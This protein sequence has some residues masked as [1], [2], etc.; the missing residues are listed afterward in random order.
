MLFGNQEKTIML[1]PQTTRNGQPYQRRDAKSQLS[2]AHHDSP[3]N[4]FQSRNFDNINSGSKTSTFSRYRDAVTPRKDQNRH[5][6]PKK[7]ANINFIGSPKMA[8]YRSQN[9]NKKNDSSAARDI[10]S[11]L[12][13]RPKQDDYQQIRKKGALN[14]Y[15]QSQFCESTYKIP[16]KNINLDSSAQPANSI[17]NQYSPKPPRSPRDFISDKQTILQK[18]Q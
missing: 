17:K 6:I 14:N 13:A 1:Y 8:A 10:L 5:Q 18:Y 16:V 4:R 7:Q 2:L 9:N 15:T 3:N 11:P 12:Q